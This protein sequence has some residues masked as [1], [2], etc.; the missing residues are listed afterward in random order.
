MK[1]TVKWKLASSDGFNTIEE[2]NFDIPLKW[3]L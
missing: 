1:N 2:L 3:Y